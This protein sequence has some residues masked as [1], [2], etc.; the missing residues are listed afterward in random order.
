MLKAMMVDD[1][2]I[3][4]EVLDI[5][6]AEIGG[7]YVAGKFSQVADAI[8][9]A[10]ELKPDLIF[11][12]IQMPGIN[13]LEAAELLLAQSPESEVIFVTAHHE[14]AIEAFESNAIGYLL[15][16][17]IKD[18]LAK[19]LNRYIEMQQKLIRR[20]SA[21]A[22]V[23]R[24][25]EEEAASLSNERK[26]L[27]LKVMGS[28]ELYEADGKLVTWRTKK[29]KE[30]FA[31]LWSF[32]G[33]PVNRYYI[34]HDLWP[35]TELERAQTLFH[36]TLYNLRT[37]LKKA[38]FSDAVAFGDE[39]YWLTAAGIVSDLSRLEHILSGDAQAYHAMELL[40]LYRGDYLEMEHYSW[41]DEKRQQV[42]TSF[43]DHLDY[44][45][46]QSAPSMKEQL[47]RR[48]I[49]LEPYTLKYYD[50]LLEH[51][52]Q[53]GNRAAAAKLDEQRRQIIGNE[54]DAAINR[55]QR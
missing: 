19:T 28:L 35:E 48:L 53:E 6:L 33:A 23:D 1:E 18:K 42:R 39:R 14:Y 46:E 27:H 49:G 9:Q 7:V 38:G 40:A 51:L 26:A 31:Y 15:K 8:A 43:I 34:L 41:A 22:A 50:Q 44:I 30:L 25:K 5:L 20:S 32:A 24:A 37:S 13:G 21:S 10:A 12:D 4:L 36:T 3:A 11:L 29:T 55:K 17:V 47:L 16:P 2:E 54:L 45:A 52:H